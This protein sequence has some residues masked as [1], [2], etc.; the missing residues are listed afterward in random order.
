[1]AVFLVCFNNILA[2][3]VVFV[4]KIYYFRKLKL[5]QKHNETIKNYK[6]YYK[7]RKCFA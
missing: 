7:P 5:Y 4:G 1:M 2:R 3:R 6:K